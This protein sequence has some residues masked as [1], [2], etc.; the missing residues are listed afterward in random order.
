ME[1]INFE[2]YKVFYFVAKNKNLT[3]AANELYISQP[4]ISQALKKLE[5][6]LGTKLF[7]RTKTGMNL[8][9]N[10]ED[11]YNYLKVSIEHLSNGKRFLMENKNEQIR[12]RIGSGTTLIKYSLIPVL[13]IFKYEYPNVHFEII[14]GI[15]SNLIDMLN[16]DEL[17]IVIL[18][19]N[20]SNKNDKRV[21]PIEEVQDVF[22]YKKDAFDFNN[23]T[24]TMEELNNIPLLLQSELS[25]S[26]KFIDDLAS[27]KHVIL[28]SRYDVASYG[29]VLDFVKQG[30][31]VGFINLNHIKEDIDNGNLEVLK[32]DFK[33]PSRKIGICINKKII[34]EPIIK[35]FVECIKKKN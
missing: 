20:Y 34:D 10:G 19:I 24:F 29:L 18:N 8:T 16:K 9:K 1:N 23:H 3:K 22:C 31:G 17:D 26:R 13:K 28:K 30:L 27:S 7:Y 14:Q 12:I 11:L 15:T 5:E 32:T 21:I 25:T 6:E 4:A 35:R 33:I 2:L